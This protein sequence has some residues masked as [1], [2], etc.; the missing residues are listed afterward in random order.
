MFFTAE[1]F[2]EHLNSALAEVGD[3]IISRP[4]FY[5]L[6]D[7]YPLV[8]PQSDKFADGR[9]IYDSNVALFFYFCSRVHVRIRAYKSVALYMQELDRKLA[10]QGKRF[11]EAFPT[12]SA[13]DSFFANSTFRQ[14]A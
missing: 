13:I 9:M 6:R 5:R 4:T 11:S 10:Q 14:V 3:P 7:I 12:F 1:Q 8:Y 2:L